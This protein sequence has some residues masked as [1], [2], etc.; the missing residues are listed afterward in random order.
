MAGRCLRN[1]DGASVSS[2]SYSFYWLFHSALDL[3]R[4]RRTTGAEAR[5]G[6]LYGCLSHG[7]VYASCHSLYIRTTS[8]VCSTRRLAGHGRALHPDPEHGSFTHS[9]VDVLVLRHRVLLTL[10]HI[11]LTFGVRLIAFCLHLWYRSCV[12]LLRSDACICF[13]FHLLSVLFLHPRV[14]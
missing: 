6:I 1:R 7:W 8:D 12:M 10:S 13:H 9:C 4:E 11:G 3:H 2:R 5:P 14:S